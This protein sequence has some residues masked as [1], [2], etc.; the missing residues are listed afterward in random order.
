MKVMEFCNPPSRMYGNGNIF[1][2]PDVQLTQALKEV[3]WISLF[4]IEEE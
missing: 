3:D 4:D 1:V 2:F